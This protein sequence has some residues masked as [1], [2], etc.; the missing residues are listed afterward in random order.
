LL[1]NNIFNNETVF[2]HLEA[3]FLQRKSVFSGLLGGLKSVLKRNSL[4]V[5]TTGLAFCIIMA[6]SVIVMML[7]FSFSPE[8]SEKIVSLTDL[9]LDFGDL[10]EPFNLEFMSFIFLNNSGHFWNPIRMLVWIPALGPL[11]VGFEILFN[12]GLIGV[13]AVTIGVENGIWYPIAGLVPH[14]IIE[15]PAFIL[16]LSSIILWQVSITEAILAKLRGNPVDKTKMKVELWDVVVLAAMSIVLL[17]VAAA[18]ET[19]VTPV[20]LGL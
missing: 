13:I 10:P 15:I 19:Y 2:K 9:S 16:Q 18:I 12:S 17:F 8:L 11:L 1:F 14:G 3:L 20:L 6:V 4:I 5:K 7:I